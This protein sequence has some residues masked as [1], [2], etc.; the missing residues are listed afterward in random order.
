MPTSSHRRKRGSSFPRWGRNSSHLA[1][2]ARAHYGTASRSGTCSPSPRG[3]HTRHASGSV[4]NTKANLHRMNDAG[5]HTG[6]NRSERQNQH[7]PGGAHDGRCSRNDSEWQHGCFQR[8]R[9]RPVTLSGRT[10]SCKWRDTESRH[11]WSNRPNTRWP[12][13]VRSFD[14]RCRIWQSSH[15]RHSH[16][17]S[18]DD[19][20]R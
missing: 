5:P 18:P 14:T 9:Q 17:L 13:S 8:P 10:H 16:R 7:N 12:S 20:R 15:Q 19:E 6:C 4:R 3:P 1:G 11:R 2:P